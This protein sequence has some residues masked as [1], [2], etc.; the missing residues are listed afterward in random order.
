MTNP[1]PKVPVVGIELSRAEGFVNDSMSRAKV[2]GW[3]EAN[4]VLKRW[5]STA[6]NDGSY[7]KCDIWVTFE[8]GASYRGRYELKH[9]MVE[10]PDLVSTVHAAARFYA[11]VACPKHMLPD[12]YQAFLDGIGKERRSQYQ[13]LLAG[14]DLFHNR[15]EPAQ[16]AAAALSAAP[17]TPA[18]SSAR[19]AAAHPSAPEPVSGDVQT[20][21]EALGRAEQLVP[22]A[23]SPENE[24]IVYKMYSKLVVN[25][26]FSDDR[27]RDH[28]V[29]PLF[30]EYSKGEIKRAIQKAIEDSE[31][32]EL[33]QYCDQ[34]AVKRIDLI[35]TEESVAFYFYTDRELSQPELDA[36]HGDFQGQLSDGYGEGFEQN[37]LF[38]G[39]STVRDVEV[40]DD[41]EDASVG[42]SPG[43]D[44][45]CVALSVD[46]NDD[47]QYDDDEPPTRY[48]DVDY[49]WQAYMSFDWEGLS[50]PVKVDTNKEALPADPRLQETEDLDSRGTSR[51][52]RYR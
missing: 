52:R 8:D 5:S 12:D 51:H 46:E 47:T 44:Q 49:T 32:Q 30:D 14:Y 13:T 41:E 38:S 20:P 50:H 19:P 28:D 6:P 3:D 37:E 33:A 2:G 48:E 18:A 36:L 15:D 29:D 25:Y 43:A 4:A 23:P 16:S 45:S 10:S 11:G 21:D 24:Q 35:P 34:P 7:H 17:D 40:P 31:G 1:T 26:E 39:S 42:R 22:D 9:W 27:V